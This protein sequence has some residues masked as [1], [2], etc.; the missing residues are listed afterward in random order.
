MHGLGK[1]N[2]SCDAAFSY[3]LLCGAQ[4]AGDELTAFVSVAQL[5][6]AVAESGDL[7]WNFFAMIQGKKTVILYQ[8]NIIPTGRS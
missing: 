7:V 8:P 4:L 6:F 1:E 5:R 2:Y 3:V